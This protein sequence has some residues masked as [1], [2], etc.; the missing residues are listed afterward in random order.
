MSGY[1]CRDCGAIKPLFT[2]T[3]SPDLGI[4]C[5]GSVPFDSELAR[6][7]DLG[8]PFAGLRDTPVGTA[9]DGL[10]ARLL[11]ALDSGQERQR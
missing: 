11:E 4:P 5:L 1:Y 3:A 2:S 8:M 7:C 10:A 9:L 6:H